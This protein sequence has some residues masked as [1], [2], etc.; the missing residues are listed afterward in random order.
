M[1]GKGQVMVGPLSEDGHQVSVEGI[2]LHLRVCSSE[3]M[4]GHLLQHSK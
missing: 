1:R 3:N 4:V 2:T